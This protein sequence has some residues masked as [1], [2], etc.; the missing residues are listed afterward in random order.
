MYAIRSYYD[1]PLVYNYQPIQDRSYLFQLI[2]TLLLL[3]AMVFF[4]IFMMRQTGGAGKI[5]QFGKSNAKNHLNAGKKATFADV[6]GA[7]EE[8]EEL[9]EIVDFLKDSK[10][11]NEIGARNNF[12]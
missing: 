2:P 5:S 7:D 8:K 1:K 3:G 12:V 9:K 10:K 4:F 6:A 11:Y